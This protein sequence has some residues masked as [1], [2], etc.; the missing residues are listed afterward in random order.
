MY[1]TL[2]QGSRKIFFYIMIFDV[3][4]K[5]YMIGAALHWRLLCCVLS[6]RGIID[7]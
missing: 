1:N 4:H 5:S 7:E 6:S 2:S 3:F